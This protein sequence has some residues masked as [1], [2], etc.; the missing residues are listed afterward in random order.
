MII[1]YQFINRQGY[2]VGNVQPTLEEAEAVPK[3]EGAG[4]FYT[5]NKSDGEEDGTIF[6][7]LVGRKSIV[8]LL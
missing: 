6:M 8:P 5:I 3:F 4:C 7:C 2:P 1:G